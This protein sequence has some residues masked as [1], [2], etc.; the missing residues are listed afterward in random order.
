MYESK[1]S[2]L[3]ACQQELKSEGQDTHQRTIHILVLEGSDSD[4]RTK[5]K[6]EVGLGS[7]E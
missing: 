1:D 2:A 4:L 6:L 3:E 7:L 5:D